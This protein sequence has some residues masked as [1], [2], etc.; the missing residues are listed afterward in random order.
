[1]KRNEISTIKQTNIT[2]RCEIQL[3]RLYPSVGIVKE[4]NF[5]E[6]PIEIVIERNTIEVAYRKCE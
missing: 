5:I 3:A 6:L 1:M 2:K 4:L